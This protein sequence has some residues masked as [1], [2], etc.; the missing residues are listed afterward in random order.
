MREVIPAVFGVVL[1][2]APALADPPTGSRLGERTVHGLQQTEEQ[3]DDA[4]TKIGSCM[5][6]KRGTVARAYVDAMTP[7][8]AAKAQKALFRE[9]QCLSYV[10]DSNLSDTSVISMPT[11]ILRGK[12]AEAL[13]KD[14]DRAIAALPAMP[15]VKEY[16]RPWFAAT[17]RDPVIDEMAVCVV[18]TN[19]RGVAGILATRGYSKD[20]GAAFGAVM[21][22]LGTCLRV[23][24]KLRA[25]RPALRAALADALYQR[26]TRP[27]PTS[28][29]DAA[30]G[31]AK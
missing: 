5:V 26:L 6:A 12:L 16:A 19:P 30:P 14:Q 20:E 11:D 3:A 1:I 25:N 23:G 2:A 27:A 29:P 31:A 17:S 21:P 7:D 13:L 4:A 15:L 9:I 18:D 24:A 8:E 22:T 28:A 10:N